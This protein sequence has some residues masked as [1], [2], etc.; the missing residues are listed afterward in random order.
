[1]SIFT[2]YLTVN[3]SCFRMNDG[4]HDHNYYEYDPRECCPLCATEIVLD[5]SVVREVILSYDWTEVEW[6]Q[7]LKVIS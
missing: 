7:K 6:S 2:L 4:V 1:M 3:L 5:W